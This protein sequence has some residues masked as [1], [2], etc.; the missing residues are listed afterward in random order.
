[1]A[2]EKAEDYEAALEEFKQAVSL[3]PGDPK[4]RNNLGS[5]YMKTERNTEA[6]QALLDALKIDPDFADTLYNLGL[7]LSGQ[8]RFEEAR[9]HW[10]RLL[11]I[12][13]DHPKA[14]QAKAKMKNW[15]SPSAEA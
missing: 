13:P 11:A 3:D 2:Y 14:G 6:E 1:M 15:P 12:H 8:S 7:L 9:P 4:F 10:S 5:I